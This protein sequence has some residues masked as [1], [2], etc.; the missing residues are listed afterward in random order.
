[1]DRGPTRT[2]VREARRRQRLGPGAAC[3]FCGEG[4]LEALKRVTDPALA[5][6]V[7]R[8]LLEA[9]HPLGRAN[10]P[11]L[12]IVLCRN[13][14]AKATESLS[15][16]AVPMW[17]QSHVLDRE[18]ARR[19]A[20]AVFLRDAANAEDRAAEELEGVAEWLDADLPDWRARWERRK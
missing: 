13:H 18:I 10:D 4:A 2:E 12:T 1:M 11:N 9:H 19:K 15:R 5:S 16:G 3:V 17:F 14:H 20:W 6:A 7:R 8:V